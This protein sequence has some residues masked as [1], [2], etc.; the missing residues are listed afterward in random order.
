[1]SVGYWY[2]L[3]IEA[4]LEVSRSSLLSRNPHSIFYQRIEQLYSLIKYT[5]WIPSRDRRS[6]I[7]VFL[8]HLLILQSR[9][10][11]LGN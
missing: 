3:A 6:R 5:V 10:E 7:N 11:F 1:M 4:T 2:N 9:K 8:K